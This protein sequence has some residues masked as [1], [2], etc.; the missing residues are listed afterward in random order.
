MLKSKL[1]VLVGACLAI[2]ALAAISAAPAAAELKWEGTVK[3]C[4]GEKEF[5]GRGATFQADAQTLWAEHFG[6]A[7]FGGCTGFK[8][9]YTAVGSGAGRT[10]FQRREFNIAAFGGTDEAP[11]IGVEGDTSNATVRGIEEVNATINGEAIKNKDAR[12]LVVPVV[13]AALTVVIN[14]PDGCPVVKKIGEV[15]AGVPRKNRAKISNSEI[16]QIYR[17]EIKTW[18]KLAAFHDTDTDCKDTIK[19]AV[20]QDSSGTTS[21]FKQWL[22]T[23]NSGVVHKE[24]D[25]EELAFGA[26]NTLWPEL[27]SIKKPVAAGGAEVAKLVETSDASI[28]YVVLADAA[29]KFGT[30][31]GEGSIYWTAL[32]NSAGE[33]E[34]PAVTPSVEEEEEGVFTKSNCASAEYSIALT[35]GAIPATT[36]GRLADW[37]KVVGFNSKTAFAICSLSYVLAWRDAADVNNP[38]G[39]INEKLQ[40]SVRDY[41]KWIT[42]VGQTTA[43]PAFYSPLPTKIRETALAGALMICWKIQLVEDKSTT[44]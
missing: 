14:T 29:P 25:W 23:V 19:V 42:S 5:E 38:F 31:E 17:G 41:I 13:S 18:D 44:C 20:R 24:K 37:S 11:S 10:A 1:K 9:K 35:G 12:L 22:H 3:K 6:I 28:G 27:P 30:S 36:W 39:K 40:R 2:A 34:D 8:P 32:L 33:M 21:Q 26:N 15:T 16:E 4:E 43:L 7:E